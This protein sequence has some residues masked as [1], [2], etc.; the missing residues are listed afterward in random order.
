MHERSV[1][2]LVFFT[3]SC[4]CY[5]PLARVCAVELLWGPK[6]RSFH[7]SPLRCISAPLAHRLGARAFWGLDFIVSVFVTN[8]HLLEMRSAVDVDQVKAEVRAKPDVL[9]PSTERS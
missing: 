1:K 7:L 4:R 3:R 9:S 6:Y 2:A 5:C 8:S